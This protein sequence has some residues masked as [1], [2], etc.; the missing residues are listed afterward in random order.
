MQGRE[1]WRGAFRLFILHSPLPPPRSRPSLCGRRS[2]SQGRGCAGQQTLVFTYGTLKQG[3]SNHCL[4]QEMICSGDASYVNVHH[5]ASHYPFVCGPYRVQFLLNLLGEGQQVWGEVYTMSGTRITPMDK[6]EGTCWGHY[7]QLLIL[8]CR[9]GDTGDEDAVDE[10]MVG[11]KAYFTYQSYVEDLWKCNGEKSYCIYSEK[12][13]RGYIRRKD[14]SVD[15]T[16]LDH[17]RV[18]VSSLAE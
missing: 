4:F 13:A 12:E 10:V 5:T 3:F 15:T 2:Q 18:F 6:L 8:I 1:K 16:F 17:M 9:G 7:E 14:R 11:T